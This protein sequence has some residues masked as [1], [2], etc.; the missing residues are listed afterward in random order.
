MEVCRTDR[1]IIRHFEQTDFGFIIKLLNEESFI[2]NI[3]DRDIRTEEDAV[4]YLVYGPIASYDNNGYG[5]NIV[6]LKDSNIPIGM[7][8]LV[9]REGLSHPDIGYAL[10]PEYWYKGYAFEASKAILKDASLSHGLKILWAITKEKN[11]SSQ[12][13]LK[14]LGFTYKTSV[15]LYG[16]EDNLYEY[17]F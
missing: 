8:G 5:L 4:N 2:K 17:V 6:L 9:K 14:K 1:L 16:T 12:S 13:L 15:N 10:I 11:L 3:A 7:C